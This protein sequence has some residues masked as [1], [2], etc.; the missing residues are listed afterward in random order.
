MK[1]QSSNI[2]ALVDVTFYK[3]EMKQMINT[4]IIHI[5]NHHEKLI[6]DKEYGISET[7][8]NL[9]EKEKNDLLLSHK[10]YQSDILKMEERLKLM[11]NTVNTLKSEL[12]IKDEK[13]RHEMFDIQQRHNSKI[14][15]T[16]TSLDKA[17][18]DKNDMVLKYAKSE[19]EVLEWKNKYDKLQDLH[20]RETKLREQINGKL[21]N[22]IVELN[23]S[24]IAFEQKNKEYSALKK[25]LITQKEQ[26]QSQALTSKWLQNKLDAEIN[27]HK[28]T[29][30]QLELTMNKFTELRSEL[31]SISCYNGLKNEQCLILNQQQIPTS[32]AL[33]NN[34]LENDDANRQSNKLNEEG[35]RKLQLN[36]N[37]EW[38][39]INDDEN[40][41]GD[42]E[43]VEKENSKSCE[44]KKDLILKIELDLIKNKHKIILNELA[45]TTFKLNTVE[46]DNEENLRRIDYLKD[47]LD[48]SQTL[49]NSYEIK[50]SDYESRLKDFKNLTSDLVALNAD[51]ECLKENKKEFGLEL[52]KSQEREK[53]LLEFTEITSTEAA[54]HLAEISFLRDK[55]DKISTE[56]EKLSLINENIDREIKKIIEEKAKLVLEFKETLLTKEKLI[57]EKD[58]LFIED[59]NIIE[60]L[61]TQVKSYKKKYEACSKDLSQHLKLIHYTPHFD[62]TETINYSSKFLSSK[63]MKS[64]NSI[65]SFSNSK[66]D[67]DT[68]SIKSCYS[69]NI[70]PDN[71]VIR[72]SIP[73]GE[74]MSNLNEATSNDHLIHIPLEDSSN[75]S[76]INNNMKLLM[77]KS[78]R[79]QKAL[80]RKKEKIEF[81]NDHI[82]RLQGEL[83]KKAKIIQTL[84]LN[85]HA[86]ALTTE[87]VDDNKASMARKSTIMS[88][89]F[90]ST[91]NDKQMTL[92]L[93][94]EINAKLQNLLEDSI[95]KIIILKEGMENLGREISKLLQ[96]N[97]AL[98]IS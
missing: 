56:N 5:K 39:L 74:T 59:N 78:I 37:P 36:G 58:K 92:S 72:S 26:T 63:S 48:E 1:H 98:K 80:V 62:S 27:N 9:L 66:E 91:R 2:K 90:N 41:K 31:N 77:D 12:E 84:L 25:E 86:G 6:F 51:I 60:D 28:E 16:Q 38:G 81:L 13:H 11:Q 32:L 3:N 61:R 93:S 67:E 79:L 55:A 97:K 75:S 64:I 76:T 88:S 46:Q 17:I 85:E 65:S 20:L 15:D 43:E 50:F 96:E 35:E 8:C 42:M 95:L 44:Q 34:K 23:K 33:S 29:K 18:N 52:T 57:N 83:H 14:K 40:T 53:R 49:I 89:I 30:I 82:V 71:A 47:A 68:S 4:L 70:P 10:F 87:E 73:C 45:N 22:S 54:K 19:K 94:L 7:K 24:V 21:K 69:C